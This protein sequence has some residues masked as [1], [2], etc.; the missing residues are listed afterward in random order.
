MHPLS[1]APGV[2]AFAVSTAPEA[3][4]YGRRLLSITGS[5]TEPRLRDATRITARHFTRHSRRVLLR[6]RS[7]NRRI[8][9]HGKRGIVTEF[10]NPARCTLNESSKWETTPLVRH[11]R[12]S[13]E[14][15]WSP[16]RRAAAGRSHAPPTSR[17]SWGSRDA[18]R[19]LGE[20]QRRSEIRSVAF[21]HL[22]RS[23]DRFY[24]F[25]ARFDESSDRMARN[26]AP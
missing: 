6:A 19:H 11:S 10:Q 9:S 14:S 2:V 18:W 4:S 23:E 5:T 3:R 1:L 13:R 12:C 21:G 25:Q 24:G 16:P 20:K 26:E 17:G 8:V 22:V 15:A 7:T